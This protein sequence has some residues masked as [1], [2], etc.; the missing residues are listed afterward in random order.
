ML[1]RNPAGRGGLLNNVVGLANGLAGFFETRLS[2]A[3]AE[4]RTA[5]VHLLVLAGSLVGAALLS[6][7]G[8]VF[9]LVSAIVGLARVMGVSWLWIALAMAGLHF[10]LAVV[11][12]VIARSRMTKPMFRATSA[13]LKKDREWLKNLDR[14][15]TSAR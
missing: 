1:F 3:A 2:L 9:L 10:L 13:E 8:Y 6:A 14:N 15:R 11:C 5:L 7:V 12:L 4:G